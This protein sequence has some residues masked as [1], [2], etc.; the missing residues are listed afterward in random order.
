M[1]VYINGAACIS[2]QKTFGF[3]N[4]LNDPDDHYT[5]YLT[6][7]EPLYKEHI[8]P[9]LA[10][11]LGKYIKSGVTAALASLND[12]S[13]NMPGAIIT[14]T[15]LGSTEDNERILIA[16]DEHQERLIN[17]TNFIQSTHNSISSQIAIMLKCH[18]YN[19]TYVHRGFS[20]ESALLDAILLMYEKTASTALIGGVD[21]LT[22][23]HYQ[24]FVRTRRWRDN[25][26]GSLKMLETP[27]EGVVPGEGAAFFL[28]SSS[29][30]DNSYASVEK[31]DLIY[32]P[33]SEKIVLDRI[34][35]M[36]NDNDMPDVVIMG[37]NGDIT[38]DGIYDVVQKELFNS[39][40]VAVFKHLCGEYDT[41]SSFALWSAAMMLKS[42]IIPDIMLYSGNIPEK[43]SK[44]LIYNHFLGDQH[45]LIM[46]KR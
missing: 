18:N 1:A 43:V 33:D 3:E 14:G 44:V 17:P 32:K 39:T 2:P 41:A 10:R 42:N 27:G 13:C 6:N 21:C 28:L 24:G 46:L 4:F 8:N 25:I 7:I 40:P 19:S 30:N 26:N 12:A 9:L 31:V 22:D 36:I 20:F 11:R 34:K 5:P 37:R 29:P 16:M 15:G 38:T 35:T 23:G 45:S